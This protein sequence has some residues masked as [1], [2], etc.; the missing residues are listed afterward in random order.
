MNVVAPGLTAD[1]VTIGVDHIL[2]PGLVQDQDQD[3]ADHDH[4]LEDVGLRQDQG[5]EGIKYLIK[6]NCVKFPIIF[7]EF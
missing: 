3:I 4:D 2:D 6:T 5:G 7:I 1:L